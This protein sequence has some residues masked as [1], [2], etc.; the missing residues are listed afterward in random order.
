MLRETPLNGTVSGVTL[1]E[2]KGPDSDVPALLPV[3]APMPI[4]PVSAGFPGPYTEPGRSVTK[5]K[6]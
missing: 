6:S 1:S 3:Y 4:R 2:V 5:G